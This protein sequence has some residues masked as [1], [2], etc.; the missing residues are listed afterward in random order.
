[1][2]V[3]LITGANGFIGQHIVNQ[4]LIL[5]KDTIIATGRGRKRLPFT[6]S[7]SFQ[8]YSLDITDG[9]EVKELFLSQRPDIVIHNAALGQPDYCA[10]HKDECLQVNVEGTKNIIEASKKVNA[11]LLF[12][13]TDFVFNGNDGPYDEDDIVDPVNYYGWS[14]T[15]G[16]RIV[17]ESG[18]KYC[19]VRLCSVYG[20]PVSGT[21][22]NIVMMIKE[23][24]TNNQH[25]KM[26]SDQIRTPTSVEDV[27]LGLIDL[28]KKE[29]SG[30]YHISGTETLTPYDMAI[31]TADFFGLDKN[32]IQKTITSSFVQPAR[33]PLTTGFKIDKA[34]HDISFNPMGFEAALKKI[35]KK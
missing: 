14:K 1:M 34:T 26:V 17:Q 24:L 16:E 4:L 22:N 12:T 20:K 21:S 18:L 19:I 9:K 6:I 30:I 13:S 7:S 28:T 11:Y 2:S 10:L 29:L 31:I 15:E 5:K 3:I 32:L 35:F 8:Y 27:A 23:K 25:V 33:R